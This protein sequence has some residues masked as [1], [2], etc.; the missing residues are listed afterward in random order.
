[1]KESEVTN[2]VEPKKR[3]R[4]PKIEQVTFEQLSEMEQKLKELEAENERLRTMVPEE[5]ESRKVAITLPLSVWNIVDEHLK[6]NNKKQG[7][8]FGELAREYFK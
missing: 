6:K 4:K 8:F 7:T 5:T 3:T 2:V 1:M